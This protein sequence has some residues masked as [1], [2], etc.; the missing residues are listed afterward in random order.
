MEVKGTVQV[1]SWDGERG[2]YTGPCH[3][4]RLEANPRGIGISLDE[5]DADIFL[6]HTGERFVLRITFGAND[7]VLS[8]G[9]GKDGAE[10]L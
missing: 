3:D 1:K 5:F 2:E 10:L 6:E 8:I 7:P 4:V 9:L